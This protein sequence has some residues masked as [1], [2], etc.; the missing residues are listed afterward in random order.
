MKYL[1]MLGLVAVAA[2]AL[3]A[4]VG[5]GMASATVICQNNLNT[6]KCSAPYPI[7]TKGKASLTESLKAV[8]TEGTVLDTCAGSVVESTLE[9]AGSAT[10]TVKSGVSTITWSSCTVTTT[11]LSGG[12]A[13]LHHIAGTD[14]GTLTT[15]NTRVTI[16]TGLFG[17]CVFTSGNGTDVGT[18]V[19]GNPGSL[20]LNTTFTKES[21]FCPN[22][23]RIT[24]KYIATEP[25]N[26][27]VAAG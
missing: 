25:K 27:W 14:N 2:A 22:T 18:T 10:T 12:F 15:F 11:T 1:K 23:I 20:T 5:A 9:N 26:A 13:E 17:S 6:E 7:G 21:G 3:M 16:N 8:T 19:G 24:G 4:F